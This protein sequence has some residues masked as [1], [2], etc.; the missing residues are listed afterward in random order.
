MAFQ[1]VHNDITNMDTDA[2]V[3][4]ANSNLIMGGGVC[5]AIFKC[6]GEYELQKACEQIG[7][8]EVGNSVIT[9]GYN[10]KAKYIIHTVGPIWRGGSYHEDEYLKSAYKTALQLA[11]E[12]NIKSI[13]FPLISSGIYGYPKKEALNIAVDT[14]KEFLMTEDMD[15]YLVVFDRNAVCLSEDLYKD[16]SHYI[17]EFYEDEY[18]YRREVTRNI[19]EFSQIYSSDYSCEEISFKNRSLEDVLNNM[20]ETFS[21]MVLR[22]IDEKGKSDVEVY[23]RANM[24]RKLFSKIRSNKNYNPKK[25]TALSLAIAME[26][27]L[28][29][30]KDLLLKAGYSLSSSRKFDLIIE[31]FIY[32][33]N[34]DIYL[35][36]EALFSFDQPLLAT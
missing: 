4:A 19:D 34:Y 29:E 32:N 22:L 3:N 12:N 25:T 9:R 8:C 30:T 5:G 7:K 11:K 13:S 24:D 6:A 2:I 36:N 10:L 21:E 28:D 20:D 31:Y 18:I 1:I 27:S 23:K 35:I 15:I 16:I 26:L 17:D 33:K 14:I